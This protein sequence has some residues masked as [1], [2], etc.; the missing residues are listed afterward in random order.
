MDVVILVFICL[1]KYS[2]GQELFIVD[3]I[4]VVVVV[5]LTEKKHLLSQMIGKYFL[6]K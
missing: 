6:L 1:P 2:G 3:V 5:T 4:N